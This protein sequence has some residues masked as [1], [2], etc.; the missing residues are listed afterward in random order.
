MDDFV[1]IHYD[2]QYLK[3]CLSYIIL[4]LKELKLEVNE[5]TNIYNLKQGVSFLG[6]RF[7]L[8]DKKLIIRINN[9]T[10]KRIKKKIK[11]LKIYDKEKLIRVQASYKGYL[12]N[13]NCHIKSILY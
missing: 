6:Y 4:K 2:K 9:Q 1:I 12:Q 10:K 3:Y 13:S 7:I 8:K 11:N 5:K